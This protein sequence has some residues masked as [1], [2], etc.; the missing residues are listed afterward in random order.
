VRSALLLFAGGLAMRVLF[1]QAT[2]D[3]TWPHSA[4]FKGDAAVWL[5][6]ASALEAGR[7]FELGVPFRPPGA[8]Y[9]IAALSAVG[10]GS[11]GALKLAW[12]VLGALVAPGVFLAL[13]RPF[14]DTVAL[15]A[16]IVTAVSTALMVLSTSLN[17]ETPSLVIAVASLC[18]VDRV[19]E[20]PAPRLLASWSLLQAAGCLMRVEHA[21]FVLGATGY[22]A[23]RWRRHQD[24]K[25]RGAWRRAVAIVAAVLA[26]GLLPWHL[27]AWG[28]LR[29][30]NTE[31]PSVPAAQA[32]AM[33]ALESRLAVLR[34][35]DDAVRQRLALPAFARR[36]AADFVAA[37]V[38]HRGGDRVAAADFGVLSEAFGSVPRPLRSF[39]FVALYGPL[40]FALANHAG[41]D[42][43]FNRGPLEARPPLAG[44]AGRYPPF[45]V[46]GLPPADLSFTY[47][48]H[49]ALV[50]DGHAEGFRWLR[51]HP[52]DAL[53]L[54][55]RKL[56]IFWGGAATGFT[57]WGW[58]LGLGGVR[59]PVDMVAPVAWPAS[60]WQALVLAGCLVGLHRARGRPEVVPWLAFLGTRV[61]AA[62]LFF[63]YARLGASAL[64]A[65]ALLLALAA[66]PL[67]GRLATRARP[68]LLGLLALGVAAEAARCVAKPVLLLDG[69]PVT[70]ADP[71]PIDDHAAHRL[72]VR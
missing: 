62:V 36:T 37:T 4:A 64:P 69:Q 65:V 54:F 18:L 59:R 61:A 1:W 39:P 28:A 10:I 19:A 16:G 7:P 41:A 6:Y 22:L 70:A 53:A 56:R 45:L 23:W 38:L 67:L 5:E 29:R 8:G 32:A 17:N 34:W 40:N 68:V 48:P 24:R 27:A 30:F 26:L 12:C 20:K 43:G 33:Q 71:F 52:G 13:R 35:E 2:P 60:P 31:E 9:L 63:G 11:V 3:A 57:G 49:L 72:E 55:G 66:E 51:A 47:P 42:G 44:G 14:G 50:N 46:G 25:V 15:T 58:P 21:L